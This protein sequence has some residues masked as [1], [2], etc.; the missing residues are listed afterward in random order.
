MSTTDNKLWD[1]YA[2]CYDAVT[3][4]IPY[5]KL[6][7]LVVDKLDLKPGQKILNVGCGTGN[8][9]IAIEKKQTPNLEVTAVDISPKMLKRA[10]IKCRN[11][12]K[13]NFVHADVTKGINFPE[14]SFDGIAIVHTLYTLENSGKIISELARVLKPGGRLVMAEPKP[15]AKIGAV[16]AENFKRVGFLKT[17]L[18]LI[19]NLP[20]IV[21]VSLINQYGLKKKIEEDYQR[22]NEGGLLKKLRENGLKVVETLPA[23]AEQDLVVVTEKE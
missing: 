17:I 14:N 6:Q 3:E 8:L 23:Y 10:E 2:L 18:T 16:F 12:G 15:D 5:Q 9:E 22:F 1:L 7:S 4:S 11:P 20:A 13:V 19:S 21:L